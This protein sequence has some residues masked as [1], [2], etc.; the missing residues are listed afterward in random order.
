MTKFMLFTCIF[1]NY[2][3]STAAP[4][5]IVITANEAMRPI[6]NEFFSYCAKYLSKEECFP[7]IELQVKVS[8]LA[9]N[10][11]GQCSVYERPDY[12]RRIE[13]QPAVVHGYNLRAVLYH[14]LFH[15]VL[16]KPHYD[17][18][19]DIMN[20]YEYEE[21]TRYIYDNWDYFVGKVFKRE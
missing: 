8:T 15:C 11:L 10:I 16:D 13:I 14:E 1:F 20:A 17:N 3:C 4:N 5:S 7:K 12:L 9:D 19:P 6:V 2:G 18:E 21:N